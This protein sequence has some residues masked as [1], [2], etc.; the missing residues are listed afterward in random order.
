M[1]GKVLKGKE[2]RCHF[3]SQKRHQ[4]R[5]SEFEA[6]GLKFPDLRLRVLFQVE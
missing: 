2:S 3:G 5:G 1:L 6:E 4:G